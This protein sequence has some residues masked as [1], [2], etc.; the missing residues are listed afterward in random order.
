MIESFS[1]YFKKKKEAPKGSDEKSKRW[2]HNAEPTDVYD[3]HVDQIMHHLHQIHKL[4][5]HTSLIHKAL[6][7]MEVDSKPVH[8]L[9]SDIGHLIKKHSS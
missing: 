3:D 2:P 8:E 4:T 7:K 5:H 6:G 1:D 9:H